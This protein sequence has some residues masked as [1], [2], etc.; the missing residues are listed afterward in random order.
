MIMTAI[1]GID[2]LTTEKFT[3]VQEVHLRARIL[4]A[5][6]DVRESRL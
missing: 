4:D 3:L 6:T 1:V 5:S 2:I